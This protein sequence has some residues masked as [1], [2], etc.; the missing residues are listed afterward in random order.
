VE[1]GE[2]MFYPLAWILRETCPCTWRDEAF[3]LF[4]VFISAIFKWNVYIILDLP[5]S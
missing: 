3:R 2:D 4:N 5:Y 1:I